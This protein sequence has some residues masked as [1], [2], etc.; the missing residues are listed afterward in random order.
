M[1]DF[2]ISFFH[3]FILLLFFSYTDFGHYTF[4]HRHYSPFIVRSYDYSPSLFT[5]T[6]HRYYSSIIRC[7]THFVIARNNTNRENNFSLCEFDLYASSYVNTMSKKQLI[8]RYAT[9]SLH[10]A[11][12]FI[13]VCIF[14]TIL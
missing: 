14:V 4:V 2:T 12:Y 1:S 13:C 11:E 7:N 8:K 9:K 10:H 5:V 3:V 6:I